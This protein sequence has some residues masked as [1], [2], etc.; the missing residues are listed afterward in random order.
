MTSDNDTKENIQSYLKKEFLKD[1]KRIKKKFPPISEKI[2]GIS[3]SLKIKK[4]YELKGDLNNLLFITTK[5]YVK[6]P[7]ERF[8]LAITLAS[9]SSDLQVSLAKEFSKEN[10]LKLIQFSLYPQ[11]FRV[12]LFSLKEIH[13]KNEISEAVNLLKE[14]RIRYRKDI[15]KLRKLIERV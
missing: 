1:A 12:G 15:E 7:K 10:R 9:Q 3:K 14:F 2:N 13:N 8:F 5:N 6:N 4:I 11:H